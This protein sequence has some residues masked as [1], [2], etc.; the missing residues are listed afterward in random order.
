MAAGNEKETEM[1]VPDAF[2][3][4][5]PTMDDAQ[6]VTDLVNRCAVADGL[7]ADLEINDVVAEWRNPAFNL[8]T[9]AW[10]VTTLAGEVVGTEEAIREDAARFRMDGYVHPAYQ[11]QGIGTALVRLAEDWARARLAEAQDRAVLRAGVSGTNAAGHELFTAEGYGM[12]R[13]FWR[14]EIQMDEP[15]PPPQWPARVGVRTFVPGQ[16]DHALYDAVQ[17]AFA[18]GW[19]HVSPPFEEWAPLRIGREDFDPALCFLAVDGAAIAGDAMCLTRM[20]AGW[21]RNLGVRRPWRR[22]GVGRAL[23]LHAFGEFYRRGM[24]TVGL[25]VD[26][27][28]PTGATHLYEQAGMHVTERYITYEKALVPGATGT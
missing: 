13:H 12:V 20:G 17:E 26:A 23:L 21:V 1:T 5:A 22:R 24:H 28:N 9:D 8:A 25:G 19:E 15:P 2:R 11:G 7:T 10:L 18:D 14:M 3:L 6:A 27:Q 4:R 16:D